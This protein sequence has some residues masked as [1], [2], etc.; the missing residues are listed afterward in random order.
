MK[1]SIHIVGLRYYDWQTKMERMFAPEAG[2]EGA[3]MGKKLYLQRDLQ[4]AEDPHAVMAWT[5]T[6]CVGHVCKC[7]LPDVAP[8]LEQGVCD[9]IVARIVALDPKRRALVVEPLGELPERPP[10]EE[11]TYAWTWEGP[12]I[13]LPMM[14]MQADHYARMT[15]LLTRGAIA[16]GEEMEEVIGRYMKLTVTDLS[17]DAYRER[18]RLA[19]ALVQSADPH[20][21]DVGHTL[22]ALMDHM[23]SRELMSAWANQVPSMLMDSAEAR[24]LTARYSDVDAG[25]ILTALRSFPLEIGRE[26]LA[27]NRERFVNRLYY[28]QLPRTMVLQLFSLII[29]YTS[30]CM[31]MQVP[32]SGQPSIGLTMNAPC[33]LSADTLM[34]N[35]TMLAIDQ[36][37]V[38]N[39]R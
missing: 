17:G 25:Q 31:R 27:G 21:A 20:L 35:G 9:F 32:V 1:K 38:Q 26:W 3:W 19:Q 39:R 13:R 15:G 8:V 11:E 12:V 36:A 24:A 6:E 34:N 10:H 7:D 28:A 14:W 37:I 23:G 22:L 4:C 30:A 16:W 33:S 5:L 18:A 2:R 29:L